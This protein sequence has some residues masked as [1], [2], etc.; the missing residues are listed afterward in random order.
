MSCGDGCIGSRHGWQRPSPIGACLAVS[1]LLL[2]GSCGRGPQLLYKDAQ[3]KGRA[4]WYEDGV[5][6]ADQGLSAWRGRP[7]W[8][9]RFRLLKAELLV[10]AERSDQAL[11]L[12]DSAAAVP[13]PGGP[14]FEAGYLYVRGYALSQMGRYP[15]ARPLLETARAVSARS[16]LAS[17]DST[18]LVRLGTVLFFL[19]ERARAEECYRAALTQADAARDPYQRARAQEALGFLYLRN[20]RYDE[21][22]TWSAQPGSSGQ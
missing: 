17:L 22:S 3:S 1:L 13:R 16:H 8:V 20:S 15:S 7:E 2:C 11:A 14:E 4:G 10:A 18:I 21:C 19:G 5:R 12:L 9:H 6:L